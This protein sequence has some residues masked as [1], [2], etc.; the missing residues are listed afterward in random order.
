MTL[1]ERS[2]IDDPVGAAADVLDALHIAA[3]RR[4]GDRT[5]LLTFD[6][7]QAQAARTTGLTVIGV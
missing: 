6:I 3:A 4:A 2:G 5:V 7:R 1:I